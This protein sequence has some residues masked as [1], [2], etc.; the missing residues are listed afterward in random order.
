MWQ[1]KFPEHI[2]RTT[3]VTLHITEEIIFSPAALSDRLLDSS[4]SLCQSVVAE[5]KNKLV[6]RVRLDL[7]HLLFLLLHNFHR[8]FL[9]GSSVVNR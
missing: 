3:D 1:T 4:P 8:G 6:E 9:Q 7:S 5:V 2:I